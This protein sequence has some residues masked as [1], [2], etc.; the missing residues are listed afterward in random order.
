MKCQNCASEF[1]SVFCP[2]CGQ[3]RTESGFSFKQVIAEFLSGL[4]N[5]EAPILK[6]FTQLFVAPGKM[7]REYIAGKRKAYMSPVKYFLFGVAF[8]FFMRWLLDWDPVTSAIGGEA[9]ETPAM[10]VNLWMSANVNLLLPL[11]VLIMALFDKLFFWR[12]PFS[13]V[14]RV[15]QKFFAVGQYLIAA[16]LLIPLAKIYP[17]FHLLNFVFI[18]GFITYSITGFHG[19][20]SF[21][22]VLKSL[23]IA[24]VTFPL[25][26]IICSIVVAWAMGIPITDL[27]IKPQ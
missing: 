17:I 6:T 19:N 5:A 26:V 9:P 12:S 8:Y 21:W 4:Y 11:W 24:V 1:T 13:F 3:K 20:S 7:V 27:M 22:S 10:R 16:T 14:E 25:Y 18:F 23:L 2:D 15:V